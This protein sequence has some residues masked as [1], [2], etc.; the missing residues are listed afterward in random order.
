MKASTT[1][2]TSRRGPRGDLSHD[3]IADAARA[4]LERHGT[5]GAVSLRMLAM[6]LGV[7][8][9]AIYTYFQDLDMVWHQVAEN[10]L[11][12]IRPTELADA[13]CP[14]CALIELFQRARTAWSR[15][16]VVPLMNHQPVLGPHSFDLSETTMTLC[17]DC[18]IS[19]RDAHDLVLGWFFG[20]TTLAAVGWECG[21]DEIRA[22]G[23]LARAYPRVLTRP[24]PDPAAQLDALLRGLGLECRC[25]T[26]R[27]TSGFTDQP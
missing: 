21:T 22:T 7:A 11:G 20:S 9:N 10:V 12:E 26:S 18:T 6:E 4:L 17:R 23:E 2:T 14:H 5:P 19:D 16:W 3:R 15:P 1:V 25:P 27:R 13:E 8:P 24:D